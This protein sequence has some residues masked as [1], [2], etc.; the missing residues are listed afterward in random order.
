MTHTPLRTL[1]HLATGRRAVNRALDGIEQLL[2][3]R[4]TVGTLHEGEDRGHDGGD[5]EQDADVLDGALAAL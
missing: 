1:R 5:D 3:Q 4:G 2:A